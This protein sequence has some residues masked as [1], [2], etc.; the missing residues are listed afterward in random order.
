[1]TEM[2]ATEKMKR[3][4][5]RKKMKKIGIL[6]LLTTMSTLTARRARVDLAPSVTQPNA[7]MTAVSACGLGLS[8]TLQAGDHKTLLADAFPNKERQK[9]TTT[10]VCAEIRMQELA[11]M[12]AQAAAEQAGL[13]T[14]P[15][16]GGPTSTCAGVSQ[17]RSLTP[18]ATKS[19][20]TS[21][22]ARG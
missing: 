14:T 15:S 19:A 22:V 2:T 10:V 21:T 9:A 18:M 7:V 6:P 13:L 3:K 5:R 1:M 8:M 4:K 12:T 16:D 17:K 11:T 20:E